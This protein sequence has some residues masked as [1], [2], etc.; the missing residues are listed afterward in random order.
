MKCRESSLP[1]EV[2]ALPATSAEGRDG[3]RSKLSTSD[4]AIE[5]MCLSQ[6]FPPIVWVQLTTWV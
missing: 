1:F 2:E 5:G 4:K 3:A 6:T